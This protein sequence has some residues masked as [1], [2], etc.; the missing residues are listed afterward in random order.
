MKSFEKKVAAITGAAS[1]IGRALAIELAGQGC[2][3][4]L[5]DINEDG[6]TATAEQVAKAGVRVTTALVDTADRDAVYGWA[7]SV[8]AEHGQ[9]NLIFNNAGVA[10]GST[11]EKT[12]VE[13]FEW[14]MNI[15]F[16]GVVWGTQAFLPHLRASG[17][18][19]IV[20]ISSVFG[21]F[22]VPLNGSY[23][24]SKFA[25]RGFT[26]CLRMELDLEGGPVSATCVHPGGVKTGIAQTARIDASVEEMTGLSVNESVGN[27]ERMLN[28]NQPDAAA[29]TILRGVR[30]NKRRVLVGLDARGAD[31]MV[32]LL[33]PFYQKVV[34]LIMRRQAE[35]SR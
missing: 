8:V 33:G 24:S 32:R 2:H 1:G 6:L 3:L 26:E 22:S 27:F 19:H 16:W 4:A 20:N 5:S 18:G 28:F 29:K 9:V 31:L 35:K 10:L 12:A 23:N 17:D 15:N 21:L 13:D 25:V 11:I 14:L 34:V 30:R 7:E